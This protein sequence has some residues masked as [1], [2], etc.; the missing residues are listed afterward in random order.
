MFI[1]IN[2]KLSEKTNITKYTWNVHSIQERANLMFLN[3]ETKDL[4]IVD[5]VVTANHIVYI[6]ENN[7]LDKRD[8]STEHAE[9]E[10]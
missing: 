2:Q 4:Q 8:R 7:K 3:K 9:Y 5:V 10:D 1:N 6:K